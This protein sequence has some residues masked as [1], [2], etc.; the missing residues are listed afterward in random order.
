MK[1]SK[2]GITFEY[3]G[4]QITWNWPWNRGVARYWKYHSALFSQDFNN[5]REYWKRIGEDSTMLA[6]RNQG[7]KVFGFSIE[8]LIKCWSKHNWQNQYI[9]VLTD[10]DQNAKGA[11]F[12]SKLPQARRLTFVEEVVVLK[13]EDR[14]KVISLLEC[15]EPSFASA[16]G[17][18]N[19][20][21][22]GYNDWGKS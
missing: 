22:I 15:I 11:D 19:G 13:C 10:V 3:H 20:C 16:T 7:G 4:D 18:V 2:A 5:F 6:V 9:V 21:V 1:L 8:E 12:W 17:L 14:S